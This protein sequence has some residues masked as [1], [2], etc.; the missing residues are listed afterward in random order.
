MN[1]AKPNT[2]PAAVYAR[3]SID[4][5]QSKHASIPA[6]LEEIRKYA[7]QNNYEVISEYTDPARRGWD[8]SR[9]ALDKM[10]QATRNKECPFKAIIVWDL[11]RF[12][13]D[14]G[15]AISIDEELF[16][17]GIILCSVTEGYIEGEEGLL[18]R[19]FKHIANQ[20]YSVQ[21]GRSVLRGL[22]HCVSQGYAATGFPPY[23]YKKVPIFDDR[24]KVHMK[25]SVDQKAAPIVRRV[26]EIY[27][28]GKWSYAGIAKQFNKEHIPS[29]L[30]KNWGNDTI[31]RILVTHTQTYLG[32]MEYNKTQFNQKHRV[33]RKKPPTEWI[34]CEHSHE[35]II[36]QEMADAVARIRIQGQ[37]TGLWKV[38]RFV[39][40]RGMLRCGVCGRRMS[41]KTNGTGYHYYYCPRKAYAKSVGLENTCNQE[42]IR[43]SS[44]DHLITSAVLDEVCVDNFGKI[45]NR[46]YDKKEKTRKTSIAK[47]KKAIDKRLAQLDQQKKNILNAIAEGLPFAAAKEKM[48]EIESATQTSKAELLNLVDTGNF[49]EERDNAM[50]LAKMISTVDRHY[51]EET[52]QALRKF[53]LLL[54]DGI[55]VRDG[56]A[57]IYWKISL[58]SLC[59]QYR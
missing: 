51:L 38:R 9:P 35:P 32:N 52:P 50:A 3:E 55:S 8:K 34:I 5:S 15:N 46:I 11:S 1:S 23:G 47:K 48:M 19:G 44:L 31:H 58:P 36:T 16:A 22:K 43:T 30:G 57:T 25:Y 17:H 29:P 18:A 56:N 10:L 42:W 4:D 59:I 13:R 54:I 49:E 26:Y 21:L 37:K 40:L 53:L 6:Q 24:N 41:T 33:R 39:L 45:L 2:I 27:S 12:Y 28:T 14:A 20:Y 7:K